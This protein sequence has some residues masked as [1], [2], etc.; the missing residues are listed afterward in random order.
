LD[1]PAA[2]FEPSQVE[3]GVVDAD[4]QADQQ[5]NVLD[6]AVDGGELAERPDEANVART[7]VMARI[8][9]IPTDQHRRRR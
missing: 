2:L 7:A 3:P 8:G 6:R 5:N 1:L 9:R 4:G